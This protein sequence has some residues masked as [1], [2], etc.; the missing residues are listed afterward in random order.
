MSPRIL[1]LIYEITLITVSPTVLKIY[2]R[3]SV[4]CEDERNFSKV[5]IIQNKF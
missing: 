3:A 1:Q 5:S 2:V 4:S